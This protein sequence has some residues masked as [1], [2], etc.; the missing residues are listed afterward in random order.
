MGVDAEMYVTTAKPLTEREVRRLSY[1]VVAAFGTG[2]FWMN[3]EKDQHALAIGA[4]DCYDLIGKPD[5]HETVL[6]VN[7]AGRHYGIG[8]E[9]G[10]WPLY[11]N[12]LRWF[13]TRLP[14]CA[15]FYGGDSGESLRE[16]T[17]EEEATI[18]EHFAVHQHLP[19]SR[20]FD[21]PLPGEPHMTRQCGFCDEPMIRY[22]WGS[23]GKFAAFSCSGCG[24]NE[25]TR[26]GGETWSRRSDS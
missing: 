14:E 13:K 2:G 15:V 17:P 16:L 20:G 25:E 18:W 19:Y 8:Y 5:D 3:R 22:G 10:D 1:E 21:R 11:S 6:T 23:H 12:L 26:D 7:L 4:P 24:L 9:R